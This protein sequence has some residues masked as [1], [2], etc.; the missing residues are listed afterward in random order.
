MLALVEA[1]DDKLKRKKKENF[2]LKFKHFPQQDSNP[3]RSFFTLVEYFVM[4]IVITVNINDTN[5]PKHKIPG[6]VSFRDT[7]GTRAILLG[8]SQPFQ[9]GWQVCIPTFDRFLNVN[10]CFWFFSQ[11]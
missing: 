9:D 7:S 6:Q 1:E 8:L 5:D 11:G 4:T 10:F 2:F 3:Q